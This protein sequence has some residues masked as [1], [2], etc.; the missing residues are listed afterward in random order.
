MITKAKRKKDMTLEYDTTKTVF[1]SYCN[2]DSDIADLVEYNLVNE[3]NNRIQISRYTRIPYRDSFKEFMNTIKDH[4][5]VL[6]IV[7]EDYLKSQACM[8]EI[9]QVIKSEKLNSHFLFIVI[10][11]E[12]RKYYSC[13]L[14][15]HP[16][17]IYGGLKA[18][19]NY[20]KYWKKQLLMSR[21]ILFNSFR[22]IIDD[23]VYENEYDEYKE[24]K[25]IYVNDIKVIARYLSDK[26][27]LDF[28]KMYQNNFLDIINCVFPNEQYDLFESCNDF[29]SLLTSAINCICRVTKTDYN[30][31]LL[32]GLPNEMHKI[33][34]IVFADNIDGREKQDYRFARLDGVIAKCY[35]SGNIDNIGNVFKCNYYLNAVPETRS[36]LVVPIKYGGLTIGVINSE[37][38]NYNHYST[39]TINKLKTI[40]N[41]F[42]V[43]LVALGY[44][45]TIPMDDIPHIKI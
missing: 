43:K 15:C 32:S 36:E 41:A 27:G 23:E 28:D 44:N 40:S 25:R 6:S 39:K 16:A 34:V 35:S 13:P 14:H 42:A 22:T 29:S 9:G 30:Q 2:T 26:K 11:E 7:S 3:T 24:I 33:G 18:R 37:S 8:Y 10:S 31:I 4:E 19:R 21:R 1:L 38:E 20:Y 5:Y 17:N 45:I 12:D